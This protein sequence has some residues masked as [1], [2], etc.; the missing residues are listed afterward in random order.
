MRTRRLARLLVA[1]PATRLG[2]TERHTAALV[3]RLAARPGLAVALA[4]APALLDAL[5]PLLPPAVA[6]HQAAIGRAEGAPPDAVLPA[7]R[8]AAAALLAAARPDAALLPLPWPEAAPGLMAALAE[9]AIP[10]VIALHL[11]A[12]AP[13]PGLDALRP[14]LGLDRAILAAVSAPVAARGARHLG[15]D[16]GAVAVVPNP[17]PA[18]S[19]MERGLARRTLRAAIGLR[20]DAP[21][22]L[23]VGRLE[24]AKGADLLPD[25]ADR[26]PFTLAVAGDGPLRGLIESRAAGDPRGLL[27]PL[28]PLADPAPWYLAADAL[29]LPSRLEGAPLVFLEAAAN[30][31]PVIATAAALEA[32]GPAAPELARIVPGADPAR[33]AAAAAALLADPPA[34]ARLAEAAAAAAA[35]L[36]WDAAAQHW[37]GLLRAAMAREGGRL[38]A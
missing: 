27:R 24:E 20:A 38:A 8:E 34:A 16:P 31:C 37:L 17:A 3:A 21:L 14:V 5:R 35:R 22:L 32:L 4:A 18:P 9:A 15:L 30:R 19:A 12:D 25:I 33:L 1:L 36:T 10:R 28:G 6:L 29:L 13:P 7:Q 11:A 23:F 26:L 2:G